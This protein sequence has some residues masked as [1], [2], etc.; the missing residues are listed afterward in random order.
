MMHT[1]GLA[2]MAFLSLEDGR[3]LE[4]AIQSMQHGG[5][6][7][8]PTDTVYGVGASLKHGAALARIFDVKGR[9]PDKS[10]P[11]LI[12]RP[13][14]IATLT[15]NPDEDLLRL[16][17]RFWPGPLT[18]VLPA[19]ATLPPEVKAPDGTV[20]VR[21]PDHSI[22][23]TIAQ[24]NGGAIAATSANLSGQPPARRAEEVRASLGDR[25]DVILD[26]GIAP[27]GLASTVIRRDG[28]TISVIREG[29]ISN[30][31][32]QQAWS[33]IRGSA[34]TAVTDTMNTTASDV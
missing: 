27:G 3:A 12:S 16:A 11:I 6:V 23:L 1:E 15:E 26:G 5:V 25:V 20:G 18:V 2:G 21:V 32:I 9:Q 7:V 4:T 22:A 33:E 24:H 30:D 10:L 28:D 8:F 31:T 29:A 13:E 19:K 34:D 17:S 14:M